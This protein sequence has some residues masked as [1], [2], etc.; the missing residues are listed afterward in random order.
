[1]AMKSSKAAD[2]ALDPWQARSSHD[3]NKARKVPADKLRVPATANGPGAPKTAS[4]AQTPPGR[5]CE[6]WQGQSSGH[7]TGH[8]KR[9]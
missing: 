1:M 5:V 3:W 2:L 9:R 8:G 4:T 6:L 7:V